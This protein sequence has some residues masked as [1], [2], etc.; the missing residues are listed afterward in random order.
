MA[1][2]MSPEQRSRTMSRIRCKN[3]SPEMII[4]QLLHKR[5]FRFRNHVSTL[6]GKPDLVFTS[7][8]VVVFIN[9][10]FWHGW[11][12]PSWEHKLGD[13]WKRK[14]RGNRLRDCRS[15]RRLRRQG[16]YVLRIWEHDIKRN[17]TT[18]VDR[19]ESV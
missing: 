4:R 17:P 14:I 2:N 15:I 3:T 10:D 13:Y 5:G 11:R 7:A 12:F 18:C 19:I 6:C 16:W 9:G 8:R 1:D